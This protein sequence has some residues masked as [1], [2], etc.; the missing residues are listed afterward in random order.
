[1][2]G[3]E[4]DKINLKFNVDQKIPGF[5]CAAHFKFCAIQSFDNVGE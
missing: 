4:H 3:G 5:F 2:L 1:M